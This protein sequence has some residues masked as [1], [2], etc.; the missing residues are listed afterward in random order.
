MTSKCVVKAK[1]D[2]WDFCG[3]SR[4]ATGGLTLGFSLRTLHMLPECVISY[5]VYGEFY[6]PFW[7]TNLL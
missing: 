5:D 6:T 2:S 3:S 1:V 7:S 4:K